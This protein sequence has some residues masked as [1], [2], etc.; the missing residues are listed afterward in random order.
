MMTTVISRYNLEDYSRWPRRADFDMV[1][2]RHHPRATLDFPSGTFLI[3]PSTF[4]PK[5]IC[6]ELFSKVAHATSLDTERNE[7]MSSKQ[8]RM[9]AM[10]ETARSG[11]KM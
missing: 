4:Y 7:D 6:Q 3:T 10:S 9:I 8:L 2:R 11:D 1:G 5:I